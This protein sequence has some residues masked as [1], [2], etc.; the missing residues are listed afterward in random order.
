MGTIANKFHRVLDTKENIRQVL[1]EEGK[2][3]PAD[4]PFRLYPEVIRNDKLPGLVGM[5]MG[6][7]YTNESMSKNPV[8]HDT[9]GN[10]NHIALKNF[11]WELDS[12]C[13]K[14]AESYK[15]S[16]WQLALDKA[17]TIGT[18]HSF[19][20]TSIISTAMSIYYLA[21]PNQA[22]FTVKSYSVK[23]SGLKDGQSVRYRSPGVIYRDINSDGTYILPSFEFEANGAW[24][25]FQF[26]K[27]QESCNITIEQI[28]DYA[29]AI[30]FDGVDDF[31]I[32]ETFPILTREK[33]YTVMALRQWLA[34]ETKKSD[35]VLISNLRNSNWD[36]STLGAFNMEIKYNET[37]KQT[38]AS[39][40]G[41]ESV[42]NPQDLP[43]TFQTK[44]IYND[45]AI[46]SGELSLGGNYLF[47]GSGSSSSFFSNA[48]IYALA[49]FDHDT[50]AEERQPVIDYWKKEFPEFYPS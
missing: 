3:I 22:P 9:S 7:G 48:A 23:V 35:E 6:K 25:G 44:A 4:M 8:W 43:F 46:V 41:K 45:Q 34:S 29:G 1:I 16:G 33:G 31:G 49:I 24:Y 19:H 17:E 47:V 40:Y 18:D 30:C 42:V 15:T 50:T 28:P 10:G 13:G 14:Y 11:S 12:G 32:C 26:M 36:S 37:S 20:I 27:I 38:K 2:D 21:S 5:Y 39:S